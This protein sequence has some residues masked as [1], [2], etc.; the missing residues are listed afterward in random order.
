[1]SLPCAP[2]WQCIAGLLGCLLSMM[3]A[4]AASAPVGS[5]EGLAAKGASLPAY[6]KPGMLNT[7]MTPRACA[8]HL[9]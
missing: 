9:C 5:L 4:D 2:P 8:G 7:V 3:H 6:S 1:M